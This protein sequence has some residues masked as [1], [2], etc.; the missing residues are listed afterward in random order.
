L[1]EPF[2]GEGFRESGG[3]VKALRS[4]AVAYSGAFSFAGDRILR[5]SFHYL[6]CMRPP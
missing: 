2:K 5:R 6:H 4:Y 3:M 1:D